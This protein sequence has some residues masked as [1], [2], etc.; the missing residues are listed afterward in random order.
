LKNFVGQLN[1][2]YCIGQ[3][4]SYSNDEVPKYFWS[5]LAVYVVHVS[6]FSIK[7]VEKFGRKDKEAMVVLKNY[8]FLEEP[9]QHNIKM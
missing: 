3:I 4:Q 9:Y 5:V 2:P 7:L 1:V 6:L 8:D